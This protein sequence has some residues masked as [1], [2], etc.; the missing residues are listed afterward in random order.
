MAFAKIQKQFNIANQVRNGG[1]KVDSAYH[2][3][4]E[5][6]SDKKIKKTG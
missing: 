2:K 6:A 1:E 3:G 4:V 5:I